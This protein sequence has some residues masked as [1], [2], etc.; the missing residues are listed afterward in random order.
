MI[1]VRH[2]SKSF[3]NLRVLDDVSLDIRRGTVTAILGPNAS[4]KSTLLKCI[5]G[6]VNP[7]SG[8]ITIDDEP[9]AGRWHYRAKLGYMPQIA[10]LPEHLTVAE[11]FA[12]LRDLRGAERDNDIELFARYELGPMGAKHLGTLSGG[13]RQKILAAVAFLFSPALLIL[14]EPTVGL[15]PLATTVFKDKVRKERN[16]GCTIVLSSHLV[17]EVE[18]MADEIIYLQDGKP[19]FT[20]SMSEIK[21]RTAET[22]LDRALVRIV[23]ASREARHESCR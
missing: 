21:Q 16:N 10:R 17:N 12:M 15:D 3:G 19:F 9:V 13:T 18:E 6:L 4:G 22:R 7:D 14:D 2:L 11:L 1:Q 23:E 8:Q 20:G 5:L